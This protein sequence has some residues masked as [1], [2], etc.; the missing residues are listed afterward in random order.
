MLRDR[1][2]HAWAALRL[3]VP[4]DSVLDDLLAQ[5]SQPSRAY[6]T[7][8]HISECLEQ[9][10]LAAH[11]TI[12]PGEVE[13]AIWFHDAAYDT[14]SDQN[15]ELSAAMACEVLHQ[16]DAAAVVQTRVRSLVLATR[17]DTEPESGDARLMVDIDLS[18]LGAE[19]SRFDE[20]ETQ[21]RSEYS[22]VPELEFR[23]ARSR[24][25]RSFLRR[26]SI[27]ATEFFRERLE[28][29]ARSNLARSIRRLGA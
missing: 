24:V 8:Q 16:A 29:S 15:E 4:P 28:A 18:I 26:R 5:Y 9:L 6:H 20:Y 14:R 19:P 7:T 2:R 27:Y 3:A 1:W 12:H 23:K 21:V 22:W 11:L 13:L 10:A 17:H 25:L